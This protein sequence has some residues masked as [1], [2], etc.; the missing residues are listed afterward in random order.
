VNRSN[1]RP[2]KNPR[3]NPA[4]LVL[5][6]AIALFGVALAGD[7]VYAADAEAGHQLAKKWCV[8]CHIVTPGTTGSDAARPFPAIAN[9]P[10]FTKHGIRAWLADPHPPM[11]NLNL[12]RAEVDAIVAYLESLRQK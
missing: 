9:D 1:S 4:S 6:A 3:Q 2:A 8:S 11:P 5:A 10:N 12:S 7:M